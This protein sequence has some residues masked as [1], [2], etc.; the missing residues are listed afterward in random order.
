MELWPDPDGPQRIAITPSSWLG[1]ISQVQVFSKVETRVAFV[2]AISGS[3]QHAPASSNF[4][5]PMTVPVE[6]AR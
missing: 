1:L 2:P 6:V 3:C 5:P 4:K